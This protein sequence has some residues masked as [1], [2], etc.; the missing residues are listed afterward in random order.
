MKIYNL[1]SS[2]SSRSFSKL[3]WKN[4]LSNDALWRLHSRMPRRISPGLRISPGAAAWSRS[5]ACGDSTRRHHRHQRLFISEPG[6]HL[7]WNYFSSNQTGIHL[8]SPSKNRRPRIQTTGDKEVT[9]RFGTPGRDRCF[10]LLWSRFRSNI[11]VRYF[12]ICLLDPG[13]TTFSLLYTR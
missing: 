12:L 13:M 7:S 3:S 9:C 10:H 1:D 6:K 4:P 5:P 8:R 11:L 2:Q